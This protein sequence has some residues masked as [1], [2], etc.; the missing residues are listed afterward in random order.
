MARKTAE[1]PDPKPEPG[2]LDEKPVRLIFDT[3]TH[4]KLRILAAVEGVSM[5]N[6]ARSTLERVIGEEFARLGLK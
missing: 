6:F 2:G 3:E 4:R 1:K 5:A